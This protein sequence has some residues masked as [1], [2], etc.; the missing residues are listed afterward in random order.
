MANKFV[1]LDQGKLHKNKDI[2]LISCMCKIWHA[3]LLDKFTYFAEFEYF[4]TNMALKSQ[5]EHM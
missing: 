1:E 4:F 3:F 2:F 5:I